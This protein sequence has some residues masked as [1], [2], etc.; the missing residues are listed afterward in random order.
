MENVGRRQFLGSSALALAS[1]SLLAQETPRRDDE[2]VAFFVVGDTHYL[3]RQEQPREMSERS[4]AIN[5][6]LVETLNRLPG[7]DL[8]ETLGGGTVTSPR[9]V[10]HVGDIIDTG[11]KTGN[12][13]RQM[14]ET[15]LAA[16]IADYGLNGRDGRLRFPVFEVH[17]NHDSP[18]GDGP[19]I[20]AIRTRNRARQG[21]AS[22]SENGVHCSWDWGNVH[23]ICA[24][25]TVGT[26]AR[27]PNRPRNFASLDSQRFLVDDLNRN[28][29]PMNKPVFV[30]H[31][32]D[33]LRHSVPC[34]ANA[35][36][37]ANQEWNPCDVHAYHDALRQNR[38][39]GVIYGHTHARRI[40]R[41][42]GTPRPVM[43]GG[44]PT[45]N[46]DKSGHSMHNSHAFFY[47]EVNRRETVVR[48][49]ASSD[50]WQTGRWTP[51]AWR[52]PV[53]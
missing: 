1:G 44:I 33:V 47:F 8:P 23:F 50:G 51:T 27:E 14:Q 34:N 25:I 32:I 12:G 11:D 28:V 41:W 24:G 16:Y 31:H 52:F 3:A 42:D 5:R 17:G 39:L 15:E 37:A 7:T 40:F 20:S 4:Q 49:Y 13:P 18:L 48:E 21:L 9:G 2:T 26:A 38:T 22:V 19:V 43:M 30:I 46:N 35:Q 36:P 6:R 10:I 45:F 29:R 53:G